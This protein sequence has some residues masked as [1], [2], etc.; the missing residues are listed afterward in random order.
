[1]TQGRYIIAS[2]LQHFG[3]RRKS[4]R[5]TDAAFET[6]LMQ[7]GEEILGAYC[8]EN[9]EH[10]EELSMQYWSLRRLKRS[11]EGL[12]AEIKEAEK[13]LAE[14]Q[15]DRASEV[16]R[17]KILGEAFLDER[18]TLFESIEEVNKDRDII[19]AEAAQTKRRHSALKMKVKVLQ[20]EE[21]QESSEIQNA[22]KELAVLRETFANDKNRLDII[23]AQSAQLKYQLGQIQ[24]KIDLESDSMSGTSEVF[25]RISKANRGITKIRADLGIIQEEQAILFHDVGRF[26]N[27]N[28]TRIDCREACQGHG[29]IQEQTRLLQQSIDLNQKLVDRLGR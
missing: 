26:L 28:S 20:E 27:I 14:G 6:H 19:I 4:K 25:S 22:R 21:L 11:E 15:K 17:S 1:M 8:W 29:G 18:T 9:I 13:I 5:M 7:D 3:V 23:D 12:L 10:I 24:G 2:L 16:D